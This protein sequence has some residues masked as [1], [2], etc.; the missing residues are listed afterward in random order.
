MD[1]K[2]R[3]P[4]L[5][6][7]W[8]DAPIKAS[9][10]VNLWFDKKGNSLIGCKRWYSE[11]AAQQQATIYI[12]TLTSL[13][14]SGRLIMNFGYENQKGLQK[15]QCPDSGRYWYGMLLEDFSH[16]LQIPWLKE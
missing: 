5:N 10:W 9:K 2:L 6:L 16:V 1:N 15:F 3:K 4:E 14:V 11:G 8:T 12:Q 13:P 7:D